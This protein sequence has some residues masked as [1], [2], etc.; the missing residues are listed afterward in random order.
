MEQDINQLR[1]GLLSASD[2]KKKHGEEAYYDAL[3]IDR[4]TE[5]PPAP[6]PQEDQG[7]FGNLVDGVSDVA[8]SMVRGAMNAGAELRET[9]NGV[10]S[11]TPEQFDTNFNSF[12]DKKAEARGAPFNQKELDM[13]WLEQR[14][15]YEDMGID[16]SKVSDRPDLN[17]DT[18]LQ[19]IADA[20]GPD[21]TET[22]AKS[23]N[24]LGAATEGITQ[25]MTGFFAL[26]GGRKFVGSMLKGGLVDATMFD[27]YEGNLSTFIEEEYPHLSNSLTE[28]LKIDPDDPEWT[29]RAK[30]ALEG[31][32]L[33]L[34]AET[35][36]RLIGGAAKFIGYGRKANLEIKELGAVSD[37]TAAKLDNAHMEMHDE[38]NS[39]IKPE[40]MTAK[41]D[42]TF[43]A[44]DGAIYKLEDSK[45]VEIQP[46]RIEPI[47]VSRESPEALDAPEFD[48]DGPA[49]V[50]SPEPNVKTDAPD[51]LETPTVT[52]TQ[53]KLAQD[54]DARLGRDVNPQDLKGLKVVP[55]KPVAPDVGTAPRP[56]L[57]PEPDVAVSIEQPKGPTIEAQALAEQRAAT[58]IQVKP[59]IAVVD[60][61]KL[62]D[63][64]DNAAEMGDFELRNIDEGGF[65]NLSR[66][67]G[68]VSG[69]K[70]IDSLQDVLATS[71]GFARMGLGETQGQDTVVRKSLQ[72]LAGS[73]GTDVNKLIRDLNV[74]ETIGRDTAARIVAGKIAIQSVSREINAFAKRIQKAELD[75]SISD[76]MEARLVDLMQTQMELMAN[77]KGL[78]TAA[79]RATAAGRIVTK[80]GLESGALDTLSAFGG[81]KRVRRLAAELAKV[82]DEKLMA[83]TVTKV[84]ERKGLRVLN[85]F[86]INSILSGPTTHALNVTSNTINVL[87]RP[88]ERALGAALN[89][90][91]KEVKAALRT[92]QYMA[93]FFKDAIQL[94]AKSGYNMRPILDDS[95][96]VE[97]AS[98][99]TTRAI[100][101]EYI[102][103]G[104]AVDILG[105]VLTM[106]SR[107][108]GA[109][110]E[111]FKQLSYRASLQARL[112]TDA[113]YMSSD[114]FLKAGYNSREEW[115]QGN[116]DEAFNSKINAEEKWQ[117]A[118]LLGKVA[119]SAEVKANFI[120]QRVGSYKAGNKYAEMALNEA[121]EATFTTKLTKENSMIA[122]DIQQLANKH[123][124]LRQIIPFIQTPMNI[125]G[126][127]WDR[128]PLL[129]MLRK[130]YRADL[131]SG[132][133]TRVA[134]A[135]GKMAIGTAIY[136]TLSIAAWDDK[137]SGGGPTDPKLARLWRDSPDWQPYSFNF[138]TKEKPYWVSYARM[139]PWTTAFGIVGDMKEMIQIGSMDDTTASDMISMFIASAGN[140]IVSKTYLQGI[141]DVVGIL[142]AK[143]SP[144]E[145]EALFKARMASLVPYSG[146]T[147]QVGNLTD[148]YTREVRSYMDKLRKSTGI[149][150]SKLPLQYNWLTGKAKNTPEHF[151]PLFHITTKGVEEID[152][153]AALIS[154]EF[155]KLGFKFEGARRKTGGVELTGEQFQRWNQLIGTI[156]V[157]SRTLEQTLAREIGKD[158]YNKDGQDYGDVPPNESHRVVMLNKKMKKFR[159][160][161]FRTLQKEFPIIREQSRAYEKYLRATRRGRDAD[162]PELD[163]SQI[164]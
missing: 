81:S 63:A 54:F 140:N 153:D 25:F 104:G 100:S 53:V 15:N 117:E 158:R 65:F 67:D 162:R 39:D 71:K 4:Q 56:I 83:R 93:Y 90:D 68:T 91:V 11:V 79:A 50:R 80:D 35:V 102:G 125:M 59:K 123:P 38:L 144:W 136:T 46:A 3:G 84:M 85:E 95:V 105:K 43:E 157:G 137:I 37:D 163:L 76:N 7:F 154:S 97:N 96:K 75:G 101:S 74:A 13:A 109:E 36:L 16:I 111:F 42:G 155:R 32:L 33:G 159:D 148:D 78:Q 9:V 30:N 48:A 130:Q 28:L 126:Q 128:T 44:P 160:R 52:D 61:Q 94:S 17:V 66:F 149:E 143:D 115:I 8:T 41:P 113:A 156:K 134:Q 57:S 49:A 87:A 45:F 98:Q 114:D 19:N 129:N 110:D 2:F 55:E 152:T 116:F 122:S 120:A 70:I 146:F 21:L 69:A 1:M 73:T 27:A 121:R 6:Q 127:A 107:M 58:V 150:R 161:A 88:A 62:L 141:S 40:G 23:D 147:N 14:R 119:D 18:A 34:G 29:N 138:G 5:Q 51:Q 99:T 20:G 112:T 24:M 124:A 26:G 132:D 89:G 72:F 77:V 12:M 64:L 60:K 131:Q 22:L 31:G 103:G 145:V 10:N 106:P 135:K 133:P 142:N 86:W 82:T 151:G 108:L 118:V 139:D 47:K 92:Y 164:D